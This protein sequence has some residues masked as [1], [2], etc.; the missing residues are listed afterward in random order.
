MKDLIYFV[1][2]LAPNLG[3][4]LWVTTQNICWLQCYLLKENST[5]SNIF[6]FDHLK[7]EI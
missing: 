7:R 1:L 2:I 6:P 4:D 5:A 3:C